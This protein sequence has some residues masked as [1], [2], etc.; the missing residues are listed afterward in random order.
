MF[1]CVLRIRPD[2]LVLALAAGFAVSSM[3]QG[4]GQH[5]AL[6]PPRLIGSLSVE[7]A[8]HQRRSVRSFATRTRKRQFQC[9][10]LCPT[11]IDAGQRRC[12]GKYEYEYE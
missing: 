7:E 11:P 3:A 10:C 4:I 12:L 6:E 8:L 2:R 9:Q 1:V 5:V